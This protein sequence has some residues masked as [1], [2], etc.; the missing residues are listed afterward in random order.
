M[1]FFKKTQ[2]LTSSPGETRRLGGAL[3][4]EVLKNEPQQ[5]GAFVFA[6]KGE[7]GSG[8]T[9]FLQGLAKGLGIRERITSPTFVILKKFSL[10][11]AQYSKF[12]HIDCYRLKETRELLTLGFKELMDDPKNIVALEGAERVKKALPRETVTLNFEIIDE[13]TRRIML[14]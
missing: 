13:K 8:K 7:L 2:Y 1:S 9:T 10:S 14:K 11:N 12:Y 3:A 5:A 4:R 6:L